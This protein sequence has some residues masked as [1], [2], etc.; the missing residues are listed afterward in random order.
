M[1]IIATQR[2]WHRGQRI[3]PGMQVKLR[4]GEPVPLWGKPTNVVELD[5]PDDAQPVELDEPA[6]PPV[7]KSR[8]RKPSVEPEGEQRPT[9]TSIK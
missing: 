4:S 2:A 1:D 3:W 5:K 8:R 6:A 7:K 9:R